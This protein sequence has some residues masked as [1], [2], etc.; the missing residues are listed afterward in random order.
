MFLWA[1]VFLQ[2]SIGLV[3]V[4]GPFG[5]ERRPVAFLAPWRSFAESSPACP[6][7][8]GELQTVQRILDPET[9]VTF[10]RFFR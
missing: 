8:S 2:G 5:F 4:A 3:W 6:G 10:D 9:R 1:E 7:V